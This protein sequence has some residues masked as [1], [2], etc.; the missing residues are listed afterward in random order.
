MLSLQLILAEF[1]SFIP[2]QTAHR[3]PRSCSILSMFTFFFRL[4]VTSTV[5]ASVFSPA[6]FGY[7][8]LST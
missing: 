2:K 7:D 8:M 4:V 3:A 1:E 6:V 5:A